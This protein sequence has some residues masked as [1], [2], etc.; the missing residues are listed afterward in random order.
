MSRTTVRRNH[1]QRLL[2]FLFVV[3]SCNDFFKSV[4]KLLKKMQEKTSI[5][6]SSRLQMLTSN[7]FHQVRKL[8]SKV[9]GFPKFQFAFISQNEKLA[10]LQLCHCRS[11]SHHPR[12]SR[13]IEMNDQHT[14]W[15][16]RKNIHS[17][18]MQ[19]PEKL[20]NRSVRLRHVVKRVVGVVS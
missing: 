14:F 18:Y 19:I 16:S 10:C 8:S 7:V 11:F 1:D 17:T 13:L 15:K 20:K 6:L 12:L 5:V 2:C 3:S 4:I 9:C